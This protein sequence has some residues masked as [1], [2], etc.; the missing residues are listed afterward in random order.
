MKTIVAGEYHTVTEKQFRQQIVDLLKTCGWEV[1][2]TWFSIHSPPGM[3]DII[4]ARERIIFRELKVPPNVLSPNQEKWRD[5]IIAAKG[6]WGL[7]Q[8]EDWDRIVE[9]V[10]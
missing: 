3:T 5:A 8:P 9:E 1:Y 4:A 6:D 10:R 2:F 7:W